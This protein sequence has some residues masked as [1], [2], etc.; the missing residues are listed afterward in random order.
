MEEKEAQRSSVLPA[1]RCTALLSLPGSERWEVNGAAHSC[2]THCKEGWTEQV[3]SDNTAQ[4]C[5][6]ASRDPAANHHGHL[7]GSESVISMSE[8]I[9]SCTEFTKASE[10][11][12]QR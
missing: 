10:E 4:A 11:A 2:L 9:D 7:K 12:E 6:V 1:S 3:Q 5:W 8:Q